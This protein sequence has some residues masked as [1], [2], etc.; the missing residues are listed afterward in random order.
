MFK[1]EYSSE[2]IL[3]ISD[4]IYGEL[5]AIFPDK[6]NPKVCIITNNLYN[7]SLNNADVEYAINEVLHNSGIDI[8]EEIEQYKNSKLYDKINDMMYD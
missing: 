6:T 8:V 1:I 4:D 3:I 7:N 2:N 5:K